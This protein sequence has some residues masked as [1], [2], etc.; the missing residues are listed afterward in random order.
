MKVVG[1]LES[2]E[3]SNENSLIESEMSIPAPGPND[4][5]VKVKAVS[6]NPV[7]TK[8]RKNTK[9]NPGETK[10]LG[11][12]ASGVVE[13]IGSKVDLFKVGDEVFYAGSLTRPG[14]NSEYHLVDE[15][16]AAK[17][18]T[19]LSFEEA[20]ALPLTSITAWEALFD[21]LKV[22]VNE[23]DP[24]LIIGGAGGVGSIAIQLAKRLTHLKIIATAS[25]GA[26]QEWCKKLGADIVIDHSKDMHEQLR[27]HG[28]DN[29][30]YVLSLTQTGAH[31][32]FIEK[33]IAPQGDLCLIDD[34]GPFDISGFKRKSVAIHWEFM[35]TRSMFETH[36]MIKQHELL[37]KVADLVD[38]RQL[39]TTIN[40]VFEGLTAANF[41]KAHE[42]LESGKTIGKIVIKY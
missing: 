13:K 15:R 1:Y 9:P 16:I 7:D 29:V 40:H 2:H 33:I 27:A 5:L 42:M 26:S 37:T 25:R 21:R 6:V 14:T 8:V 39:K 18:P 34:P 23:K 41:K 12:D 4:I 24:L 17:K 36:D 31:K 35:F 19:S 20:A 30:R 10:I 38:A 22:L 11:W 3:I 28:L 32:E